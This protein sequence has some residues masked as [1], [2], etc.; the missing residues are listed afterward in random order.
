MSKDD[1]SQAMNLVRVEGGGHFAGPR[2]S[3]LVELAENALGVRFPPSYRE[4]VELYGAGSFGAREFYGVTTDEFVS[5]S[6]PNAIWIT[7]DERRTSSLPLAFVI[8]GDAG[9]G[10][11]FV[12]DTSL[13]GNDSE[14]P[15]RTWSPA[16]GPGNVVAPDFG[17]HFLDEVNGELVERS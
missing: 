3:E 7:L 12:I 10:E 9:D 15:V 6:I 16:L 4:F 8:I 2:S 17:R 5:A 1:L 13:S 11:Y 14:S